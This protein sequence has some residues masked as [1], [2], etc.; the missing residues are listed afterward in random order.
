MLTVKLTKTGLID[1]QDD[2]LVS[3]CEPGM[4]GIGKP[5]SA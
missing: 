5:D 4:L 2:G 1:P 3:C